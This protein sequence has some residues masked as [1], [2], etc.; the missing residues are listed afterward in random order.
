M[1]TVGA[2]R[3]EEQGKRPVGEVTATAGGAGR[4]PKAGGPREGVTVA[5]T[6]GRGGEGK[7]RK[8]RRR[9]RP[10]N[11]VLTPLPAELPDFPVQGGTL[12]GDI[13]G[14]INE[15]F[16]DCFKTFLQNNQG[17]ILPTIKLS[18]NHLLS[19]LVRSDDNPSIFQAVGLVKKYFDT[20]T[21]ETSD[22][23]NVLQQAYSD[24]MLLMN[25]NI[26]GLFHDAEFNS[27]NPALFVKDT[28]AECPRSDFREELIRQNEV[29]MFDLIFRN[30]GNYVKILIN[31]LNES[32]IRFYLG[33]GYAWSYNSRHMYLSSDLDFCVEDLGG[34]SDIAR[35]IKMLIASAFGD[36]EELYTQG[37]NSRGQQTEVEKY[38]NHILNSVLGGTVSAGDIYLSIFQP[39]NV[40]API[41]LSVYSKSRQYLF[42]H[43]WNLV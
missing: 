13:K 38:L 35:E 36:T 32:G 2:E 23:M 43:L 40:K 34:G 26:Q 11:L 42:L 9:R 8:R 22:L 37:L 30:L 15:D 18:K 33:G 5:A 39:G 31:S 25:M 6:A 20:E 41:K 7:R 17:D 10:Q 27:Y 3:G 21:P 19:K 12:T 24:M 29:F 4:G 16:K 28:V 14:K 1:Q